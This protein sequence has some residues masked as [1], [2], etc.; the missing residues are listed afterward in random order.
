MTSQARL[1]SG[2]SAERGREARRET[3]R[4]AH[5][6]WAPAP[7]RPDPVATLRSA[8]RDRAFRSWCRS[9]TGGCSSRPSPSTAG[10][11]AV[12]AD[13]LAETPHS[14]INV[15]ACGDAH[16]SNFGGFAAPDRRLIFGPNDFDETLPGPWEWDVK[17]LAASVEIA[18]RD[19]GP[20]AEPPPLDRQ[21]MRLRVPRGRCAPSPARATWT[22]GTS[23]S[24]PANWSHRFGG[25]LGAKG[26]IVFAKP[27]ERARRKTSL[28][29]VRKLTERVD[30]AAALPPRPAAAGAAARAPG[31]R[32]HPDEGEFV[33]E[34]LS[35]YAGEPRRRPPLPV[36]HLPL[37]RHGPQGRRRGQRRH[38][39][40][41]LPA[42]RPRG[43][44]PPGAAGQGGAA[45]GARALPGRQRVREQRRARRA[46]ASRSHRPS[47]TS[48]SAGSGATGLEGGDPRLLRS[49][50]L[51][52]EGI[53]RPLDAE[54]V[55]PARLLEGLRLV[56]GP[57]PRPLGRPPGDRRLPRRR[58]KFD[59]A[60][61]SSPPPTPTRTNATTSASPTPWPAARSPSSW[62]SEARRRACGRMPRNAHLD[63]RHRVPV[64]IVGSR[65][66]RAAG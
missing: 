8:G 21:L 52:L 44:G 32:R 2:E 56:P 66:P 37:R 6:D 19:V 25:E 34:L 53:S 45:V 46:A 23:G 55:G 63:R 43:Q 13:D 26:R 54:R 12:M 60:I 7:G 5:G 31:P 38:A 65:H 42:G 14:G 11:A 33:R 18:G 9:A 40:L 30:G 15:Q 27:F 22:S 24:T 17:R 41:G 10:A 49:P 59:R 3:P 47:A 48:S 16:I 50:A 64:I 36:Q 28:R 51:G 20:R 39:R 61:A 1:Q 57:G 62:A 4:S 58:H 35:D 29:A